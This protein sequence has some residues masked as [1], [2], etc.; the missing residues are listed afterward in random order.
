MSNDRFPKEEQ[1]DKLRKFIIT[2]ANLI[3]LKFNSLSLRSPCSLV[4]DYNQESS[5]IARSDNEKKRKK[6]S[7]LPVDL[8]PLGLDKPRPRLLIPGSGSHQ[9]VTGLSMTTCLPFAEP[10]SFYYSARRAIR[11]RCLLLRYLLGP[12]RPGGAEISRSRSTWEINSGCANLTG[13]R[14][15]IST[16]L[17]TVSFSPSLLG[18]LLVVMC[19]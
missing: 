1:I 19:S 14:A 9:R 11:P 13:L 4:G 2:Y 17:L 18:T 16:T 10:L 15:P 12:C 7:V 3:I 6:I 8:F 5:R